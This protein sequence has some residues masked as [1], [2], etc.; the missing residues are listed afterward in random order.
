MRVRAD[1][2]RCQGHGL[3]HMVAP[4]VFDLRADDGHVLIPTPD[5][6]PE[7][8]DDAARGVEGCP[9]MALTLEP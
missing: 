4:E 3:C 1:E 6:P 7:L 8:A 9:E 2:S 5:V